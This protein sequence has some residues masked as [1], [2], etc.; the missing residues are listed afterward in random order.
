[1]ALRG[2]FSHTAPDGSS[3]RDRAARCGFLGRVGEMLAWGQSSGDE[4][5]ASFR[6]SPDH[7]EILMNPEFDTTGVSCRRDAAGKTHWAVVLGAPTP[8]EPR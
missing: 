5:A 8:R 2:H 6:D 7:C 4:A 1:M 3:P